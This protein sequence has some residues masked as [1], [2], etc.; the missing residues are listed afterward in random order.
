[1]KYITKMVAVVLGVAAK[2][3][4]SLYYAAFPDVNEAGPSMRK[5]KTNS[6]FSVRCLAIAL[7]AAAVASCGEAPVGAVEPEPVLVEVLFCLPGSYGSVQGTTASVVAVSQSQST[8]APDGTVEITF[9]H[10]GVAMA[11]GLGRLKAQF[12]TMD[13]FQQPE[14]RAVTKAE[15]RA[16][17][18]L[19]EVDECEVTGYQDASGEPAPFR[20]ASHIA[21]NAM[22]DQLRGAGWKSSSENSQ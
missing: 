17:K 3:S 14:V 2:R 6:V 7:C 22:L 19:S 11:K 9:K 10:R 8:P 20:K 13:A 12:G 1:M 18:H 16:E 5:P 15:V 21:T 4:R